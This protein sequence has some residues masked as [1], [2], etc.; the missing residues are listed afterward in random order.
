MKS[1][2]VKFINE[3]AND[4]IKEKQSMLNNDKMIYNYMIKNNIEIFCGRTLEEI[5][6]H[7]AKLEEYIE[8]ALK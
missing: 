6:K 4:R 3:L 2:E 7:I 1:K 8:I 5:E